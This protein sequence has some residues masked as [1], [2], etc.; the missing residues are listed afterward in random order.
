MS[1]YIVFKTSMYY[2]TSCP[3]LEDVTEAEPLNDNA[4]FA[5]AVVHYNQR[6]LPLAE[7]LFLRTLDVNSTHT[8][9][10]YNL[11]VMYVQT[12]RCPEAIE[13]LSRL[14]DLQPLH[15]RGL[16][17]LAACHVYQ[18]DLHSAAELYEQALVAATGQADWNTLANYGE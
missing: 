2:H 13:M 5:L 1:K 9:S 3:R 15:E 12:K 11:G 17:Q 4:L 14:I 8:S 16:S 6:H 7:Q 18:N 10:L